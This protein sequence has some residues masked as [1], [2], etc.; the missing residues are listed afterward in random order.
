MRL[1]LLVSI[2]AAAAC[3]ETSPTP[4]GDQPLPDAFACVD[5]EY[6][7]VAPV[8]GEH[9]DPDLA[10]LIDFAELDPELG[11]VSLVVVDDAGTSYAATATSSTPSPNPPFYRWRFDYT[12]APGRRYE[13]TVTP[14]EQAT[15]TVTFITSAS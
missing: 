13:L 7:V 11:D 6:Q 12:L 15:A 2:L 5:G 3:G 14:A 4:R 8:A 9:Y 1:A 10:V